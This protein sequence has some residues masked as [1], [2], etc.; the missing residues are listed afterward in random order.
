MK[1]NIKRILPALLALLAAALLTACNGNNAPPTETKAPPQSGDLG[2]LASDYTGTLPD[3]SNYV[4]PTLAE[5]PTI[6]Q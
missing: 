4:D 6:N 1:K 3:I 2:A 5:P